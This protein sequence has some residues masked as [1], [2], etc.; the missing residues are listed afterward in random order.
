MNI[1]TI[2]GRLA[3]D[4]EAKETRGGTPVC[5]LRIAVEDR[6]HTSFIPVTCYGKLAESASH[7]LT[8][9]RLV[10][11]TGRLVQDEWRNAEGEPR[12]RLY[13]T[14]RSVDFLDSPEAR[15]PVGSVEDE[16]PF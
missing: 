7:Y 6:D 13:V 4:P 1:T 12:S 9:G 11:I 10:G 2:I 5:E 15:P 16:E 14:A 3:R 8:K